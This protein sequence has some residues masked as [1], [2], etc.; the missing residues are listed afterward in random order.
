MLSAGLTKPDWGQLQNVQGPV[1]NENEG[2]LHLVQNFLRI[3]GWWQ[4]SIQPSIRPFWVGGLTWLRSCPLQK[5]ASGEIESCY[6][7]GT[8]GSGDKTKAYSVM[9]WCCMFG[10]D[11]M[12][13][14]ESKDSFRSHTRISI[15][16][17]SFS[18]KHFLKGFFFFWLYCISIEACGLLSI[19]GV[20]AS[21]CSGCSC[22]AQAHSG[23]SG[24]G[25]RSQL[26]RGVWD[27][28][29]SGIEPVSLVMA[30]GFLTT[31]PPR[32]P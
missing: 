8:V 20:R 14:Y 9:I 2:C 27:L 32:K 17:F 21:Q 29:G 13:C 1:Q 4:Q 18:L 24:C 5:P 3:S 22:G 23:C 16:L 31:G 10:E 12:G 30:G 25:L 28:P 26:P 11:G 6:Y 19:C 15:S 7:P